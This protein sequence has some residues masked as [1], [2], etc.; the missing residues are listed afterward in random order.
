MIWSISLFVNNTLS[1]FAF[2]SDR[3]PFWKRTFY[4]ELCLFASKQV[5]SELHDELTVINRNFQLYAVRVDGNRECVIASDFEQ[6]LLTLRE[7]AKEALLDSGKIIK[8]LNGTPT[9]QLQTALFEVKEILVKNFDQ[10]NLR[11]EALEQLI[12][13]SEDLSLQTK[14]FAKQSAKLNGCCC[15]V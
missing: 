5:L 9:R 10:L 7:I 1:D 8:L 13:R 12:D 6:D 2:N 11:N 3:V 15:I 14:L 4:R